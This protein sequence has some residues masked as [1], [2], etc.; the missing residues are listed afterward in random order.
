MSTNEG[1]KCLTNEDVKTIEMLAGKITPILEQHLRIDSHEIREV[2]F[3]I[4]GYLETLFHKDIGFHDK[5]TFLS[6]FLV[7]K[8]GADALHPIGGALDSVDPRRR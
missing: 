3:Q 4:R 6:S 1:E 2:E 5:F 8:L 7:E